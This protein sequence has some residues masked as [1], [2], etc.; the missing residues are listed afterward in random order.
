MPG[1]DVFEDL[2]TL[3]QTCKGAYYECE[4]R[5]AVDRHLRR[6]IDGGLLDLLPNEQPAAAGS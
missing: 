4:D 1:S 6:R 2:A 3:K 5:E